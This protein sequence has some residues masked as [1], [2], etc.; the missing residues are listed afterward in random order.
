MKEVE[1]VTLAPLT[2]TELFGEV[3]QML[4][5]PPAV[6]VGT[7]DITK[8]VLVVTVAHPPDAATV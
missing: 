8:D 3:A 6:A 2:V 4:V 1:F 5:L 7:G